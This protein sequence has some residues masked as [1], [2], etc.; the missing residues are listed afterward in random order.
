MNIEFYIFEGFIIGVMFILAREVERIRSYERK[1]NWEWND[2]YSYMTRLATGLRGK[3]LSD[4][5]VESQVNIYQNNLMDRWNK[6]N[7]E[8][9]LRL[10][11]KFTYAVLSTLIGSIGMF[12]LFT[13]LGVF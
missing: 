8:T 4:Q 3:M 6:F 13:S 1:M 10:K 2:R 11:K 5:Y 7:L 9:S 12:I